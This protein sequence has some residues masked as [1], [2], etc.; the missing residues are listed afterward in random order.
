MLRWLTVSAPARLGSLWCSS[1][2]VRRYGT[3][4]IP[5]HPHGYPKTNKKVNDQRAAAAAAACAAAAASAPGVAAFCEAA[6]AAR[7]F[8]RPTIMNAIV[9]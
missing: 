1:A 4:Q 7:R 9:E 8:P 2:A 5:A 6:T 3:G